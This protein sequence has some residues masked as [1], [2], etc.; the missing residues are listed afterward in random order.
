V[1]LSV[2]MILYPGSTRKLEPNSAGRMP[3][4]G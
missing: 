4:K 3:G 2:S 1:Y